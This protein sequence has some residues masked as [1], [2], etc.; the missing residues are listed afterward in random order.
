MCEGEEW[1]NKAAG[2]AS[3]NGIDGDQNP[4]EVK[5]DE[6]WF[7]IADTDNQR[8]LC[9][10]SRFMLDEQQQIDKSALE[11]ETFPDTTGTLLSIKSKI[12]QSA[13]WTLTVGFILHSEFILTERRPVRSFIRYGRLA[14]IFR[15]P[16][17]P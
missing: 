10:I 7:E 9:R 13:S 5:V 12:T 16:M 4:S 2:F 15:E 1:L 17:K 6:K 11:L 8:L 3:A 14:A